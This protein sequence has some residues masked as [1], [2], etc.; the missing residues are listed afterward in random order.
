MAVVVEE[1]EDA[2]KAVEQVEEEDVVIISSQSENEFD[3][4][5]SDLGDDDR[6][7]T[8]DNSDSCSSQKTAK[9][10]KQK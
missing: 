8:S 4:S 6:L 5:G 1:L 9:V 10:K 3:E 2:V 7:M